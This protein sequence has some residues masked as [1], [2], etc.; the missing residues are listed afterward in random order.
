MNPGNRRAIVTALA[1]NVGIAVAK[2]VGYIVT[3]AASMLAE[4]VHSAADSSNQLLLLWGG[5]SARR[6]AS[7]EHPFGYGRERYFWSFV[8][9]LVI[10]SLGGLFS[11]YEGATK[12]WHPHELTQPGWAVG[13][14][15]V[16]ALLEGAAFLTA[17]KQAR[18]MKQGRSWWEFIRHTKNPEL[19][20]ILLEDFGALCGLLLALLGI[21]L[22]I[23]TGNPLFDALGSVAIGTL[24]VAIA[25]VLAIEMKSLLIGESVGV[26]N[27][28]RIG[29]AITSAKHVHHVIHMRTQHL[30]PEEVLVGA[31]VEFDGELC[32]RELSDAIDDVEARIREAL[33]DTQVMIYIEPD[34]FEPERVTAGDPATMGYGE[35]SA[36]SPPESSPPESSPK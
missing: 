27:R 2:L 6:D 13:I 15:C 24:L 35:S 36:S 20:V 4:A 28:E 8:V 18:R 23:L 17:A 31:K 21:G 30:G 1:A 32:F 22:A 11:I 12:L 33:P 10:F 7:P 19:P 16:A 3:G 9:A 29:S 14:L 34:V 25:V 26:L 5:A